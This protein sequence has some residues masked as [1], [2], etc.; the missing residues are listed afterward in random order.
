MNRLSDEWINKF[1]KVNN[2]S[3]EIGLRKNKNKDKNKIK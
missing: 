3:I 2:M 1:K